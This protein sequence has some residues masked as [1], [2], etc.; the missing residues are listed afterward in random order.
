METKLSIEIVGNYTHPQCNQEFCTVC[1]NADYGDVIIEG[2]CG[3]CLLKMCNPDC[4]YACGYA[5]PYGFVPE[6]GCPVHDPRCDY[7]GCQ[8][9]VCEEDMQYTPP[10][11]RFCKEHSDAFNELIT[12]ETIPELISLWV[13]SLGGTEKAARG[14]THT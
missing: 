7:D 5:S 4:G 9:D 13:K 12:S 10:T 8:E 2:I 1:G 3:R 11:K 14:H 6:D